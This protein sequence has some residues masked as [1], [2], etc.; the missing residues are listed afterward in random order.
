[1]RFY[2]RI[3]ITAHEKVDK[4]GW[5]NSRRGLLIYSTIYFAYKRYLE[6]RQL[7][8]QLKYLKT[9][10]LGFSSPSRVIDV[11]SHLGFFTKESLRFF[12][13]TQVIAMEP[14]GK[15]SRSF[16]ILH[17]EII[18]KEF[19]QFQ[20]VA[21]WSFKGEI[22]FHFESSNTANNRFDSNSTTLVPC[23]TVDSLINQTIPSVLIL[24]IDVQGFEF[25]VLEGAVET[26]KNHKVALLIELDESALRARGKSS[27]ELF[28]KLSELGFYPKDFKDGGKLTL[29]QVESMLNRKDCLDFLFISNIA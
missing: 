3:L 12:P 4:A 10:G 1:M 13:L 9:N 22:P 20:N 21:A 24:K 17:E 16:Q 6:G 5:L 28:H 18:T 19:V 2:Q 8:W 29:Q 11:G 15:N 14:P 27:V 25:E 23:L 26:L 7:I